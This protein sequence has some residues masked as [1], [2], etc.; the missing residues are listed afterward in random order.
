MSI[1]LSS[2][3]ESFE[4]LALSIE[5]L[6]QSNSEVVFETPEDISIHLSNNVSQKELNKEVK[7]KFGFSKQVKRFSGDD[8]LVAAYSV[9]NDNQIT[10]TL[11]PKGLLHKVNSL[12]S[13][14]LN[15]LDKQED[16]LK[17]EYFFFNERFTSSMNELS[18]IGMASEQL[19]FQTLAPNNDL[20]SSLGAWPHELSLMFDELKTS[21]FKELTSQFNDLLSCLDLFSDFE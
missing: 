21:N 20:L 6:N 10:A 14:L 1:L 17:K 13:V 12:S 11:I 4:E 15:N 7:T 3:E 8:F 5:F 19:M 2:I 16:Q 18:S 9:K